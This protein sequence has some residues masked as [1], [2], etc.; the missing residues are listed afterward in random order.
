MATFH[1]QGGVERFQGYPVNGFLLLPMILLL[2]FGS[3]SRSILAVRDEGWLDTP[4]TSSLACRAA[5]L[6][7]LNRRCLQELGWL[8][9][10]ALVAAGALWTGALPLKMGVPLLC[11][12]LLSALTFAGRIRHLDVVWVVAAFVFS[13]AGDYFLSNKRGREE[14]FVIGI[15]LFLIAH[16]GYL[17]TAWLNGKVHRAVLTLLVVGFGAYYVVLLY[18]AIEG[19]VLAAAVLVYLLVSCLVMAVAAGL[20][21]A[22]ALKIWY[23][24]GIALIVFSDTVISFHEFLGIRTFNWLILPTYYLAHLCITFGLIR[25]G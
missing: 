7:M 9:L 25:R 12:V 6:I 19:S 8:V 24:L 15:G 23:V 3:W 16:F 21:W 10:P 5:H 22:P 14:Y 1:E 4:H 11:V 2:I 20:R 13:A 18:P 17:T